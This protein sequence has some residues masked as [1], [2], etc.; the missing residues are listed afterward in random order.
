VSN[1]PP[2][3]FAMLRAVEVMARFIEQQ[4]GK[5]PVPPAPI[6]RPVI[7]FNENLSFEL[8]KTTRTEVEQTF[9]TGFPYPAQGFFSY[10]L[11]HD[12]KPALISA[13]YDKEERLIGV[14]HYYVTSK[15]APKLSPRA[16][17]TFRLIP[18]EIALG[19]PVTNLSEEFVPAV[20]G[21]A[22][23]IYAHRYEVRFPGG[24]AYAM[25]NATRIERLVLYA[26][27]SKQ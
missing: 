23:A 13:F 19:M 4:I 10:G 15:T 5:P 26:D 17:G 25:G 2:P 7:L 11:R 9:G 12:G 18:G 16:I 1:K 6:D 21:P 20:G 3:D 24:V 22:P 14:E 8:D 27:R